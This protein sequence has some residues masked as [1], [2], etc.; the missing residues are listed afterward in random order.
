MTIPI[1]TP[2]YRAIAGT[3]YLLRKVESSIEEIHSS[4]NFSIFNLLKPFRLTE[5]EREKQLEGKGFWERFRFSFIGENYLIDERLKNEI[6]I[7]DVLKTLILKKID[8]LEPPQETKDHINDIFIHKKYILENLRA[9]NKCAVGIS[10]A[11]TA[12][13]SIWVGYNCIRGLSDWNK[14]CALTAESPSGQSTINEKCPTYDFFSYFWNLNKSFFAMPALIILGALVQNIDNEVI[15][16]LLFSPLD[17]VRNSA[18]S[19]IQRISKIKDFLIDKSSD[20]G[21]IK[22]HFEKV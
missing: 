11:F 13:M 14:Y 3:R 6:A 22:P 5:K 2:E 18:T 9:A 7:N 15:A 17:S 21:F 10:I 20:P 8:P 16:K 12:A 19:V 1:I 4:K